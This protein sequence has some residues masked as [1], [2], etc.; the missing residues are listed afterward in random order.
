MFAPRLM[1]T[2]AA[3]LLCVVVQAVVAQD[4]GS[5][6]VFLYRGGDRDARLLAEA[7]REGR[8]TLYTSLA[9]TESTPLAQ[10]FETAGKTPGRKAL[11]GLD[12]EERALLTVLEAA[13][14]AP[15]D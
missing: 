10:A 15:G 12:A 8:V 7:R 2:V 5:G 4:R 3:A 1:L 11:R 13:H 9:P 6:E 14:R